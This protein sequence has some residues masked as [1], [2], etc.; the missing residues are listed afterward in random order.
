MTPTATIADMAPR[1]PS[2]WMLYAFTALGMNVYP[3]TVPAATVARRRAAN[4]AA[5]IARRAGRRR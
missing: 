5:R 3:G 1:R 4:K 2:T